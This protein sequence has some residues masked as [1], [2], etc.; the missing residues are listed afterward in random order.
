[1]CVEYDGKRRFVKFSDVRNADKQTI[2]S[3]VR[4]LFDIPDEHDLDLAFECLVPDSSTFP[5]ADLF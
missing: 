5:S 1:M 4:G 3:V 2:E